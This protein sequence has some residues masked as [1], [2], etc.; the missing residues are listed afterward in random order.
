V[1]V[2]SAHEDD[3]YV[4]PLLDAGADGYLLKTASGAELIRAVFTVHR[5]ETALDPAVAHKVVNRLTRKQLYRAEGMA[6]GLTEREVEV[7]RCVTRGMSN[8]EVGEALGI[9]LQTVQ[10]HLRNIYG[11]LGVGDRTE[12]VAFAIREG[13]ISV[14]D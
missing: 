11:K 12:A 5:G 9:S 10:V 13:W 6:E 1:L 4:F 8:K 3:R 7:L 2:L 14:D